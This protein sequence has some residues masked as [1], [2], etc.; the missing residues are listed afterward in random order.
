[1]ARP[2]TFIDF[3]RLQLLTGLL[4]VSFTCPTCN[5]NICQCTRGKSAPNVSI[6]S[7]S[8]CLAPLEP[9]HLLSVIHFHRHTYIVNCPCPA[10]NC[11]SATAL[12]PLRWHCP[13]LG[14][15]LSAPVQWRVNYSKTKPCYCSQPHDTTEPMSIDLQN[16]EIQV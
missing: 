16:M 5:Y 14:D 8:E 4:A 13:C 7:F 2:G 12:S 3:L 6:K 1:M 11:I 9:S 15:H 10:R